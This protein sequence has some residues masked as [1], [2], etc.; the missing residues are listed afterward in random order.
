MT[1]ENTKQMKVHDANKTTVYT[2]QNNQE[3]IGSLIEKGANLTYVSKVS[4]NNGL[5]EACYHG[6][7]NTGIK[8]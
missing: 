6:F 8:F 2:P 7:I 1:K 4:G 3:K 5:H